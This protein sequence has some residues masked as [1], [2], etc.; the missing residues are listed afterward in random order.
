M[1]C[2]LD[3]PRFFF[4]VGYGPGGPGFCAGAGGYPPY[5]SRSLMPFGHRPCGGGQHGALRCDFRYTGTRRPA[6]AICMARWMET[7]SQRRRP[8]RCRLKR[9]LLA[10]VRLRDEDGA[11]RRPTGA[12]PRPFPTGIPSFRSQLPTEAWRRRASPRHWHCEEFC[13]ISLTCS[14]TPHPDLDLALV[15]PASQ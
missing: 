15:T 2:A 11:R 5:L 1:A 10:L 4:A 3:G 6:S 14:D 8:R 12:D 7:E 9:V 13:Q